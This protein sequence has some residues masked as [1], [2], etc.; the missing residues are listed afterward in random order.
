MPTYLSFIFFGLN[1]KACINKIYVVLFITISCSLVG[2]LVK[3]MK[4]RFRVRI[5]TKV[6]FLVLVWLIY[7]SL[8]RRIVNAQLSHKGLFY[9]GQQKGAQYLNI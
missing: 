2:Q 5:L 8:S 7:I 9:I 6:N 3:V 1:G 4:L